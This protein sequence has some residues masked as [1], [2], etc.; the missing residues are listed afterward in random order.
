M[1]VHFKRSDDSLLG[2]QIA[3][4]AKIVFERRFGMRYTQWNFDSLS[5]TEQDWV[6][7]EAGKEA[8]RKRR[9]IV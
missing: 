3:K 2:R 7:T 4:E 8:Q 6:I 1:T 5:R 9:T